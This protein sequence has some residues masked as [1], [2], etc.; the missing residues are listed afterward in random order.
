MKT[1]IVLLMMIV[2]LSCMAQTPNDVM[3]LK[4]P[5]NGKWGY[6]SK[7][8]NR[9]SP[10]RGLR[11]TAVNLLGK[12]QGIFA[13]GS[14]NLIDW[15]VPA[16][17]DAAATDF[18]EN[19]A[20]VE[21]GGKVGFI[22]VHNRF[23]IEPKFEPMKNLEGFS[24]G[25]AAVKIGDKY[26][27][28][29]KRGEVIIEPEFELAR[30]FRDNMLATVKKDGKYGAIDI[31]GNLV[32]E[33]KYVLEEA[34]IKVPIS[35][36]EYREAAKVAK[37]KKDADEY[38]PRID[39]LQVA[40]REA[41]KRINDSVWSQTLTYSTCVNG[42]YKGVS[43]NYGRV[44]IPPR[45]LDVHYDK[46]NHLYIVDDDYHNLKGVYS[47]KGDVIF[48]TLFDSIA[49]FKN[50]KANAIVEGVCGWIDKDGYI[51]PEFLDKLCDLGLQ[52]ES[53]GD[54]RAARETYRRIL[55]IDHNHVMTLNNMALLDI[56]AHNYND[57]I[58]RLKLANKL[59]P[60]NKLIAE[61]LEMAKHDRKERRWNRLTGALTTA[62]VVTGVT[63]STY[64]VTTGG[65]EGLKAANHIMSDLNTTLDNMENGTNKPLGQYDDSVFDVE[66]TETSQAIS[67]TE[68]KN[69]T[70]KKAKD[71]KETYLEE[72][73]AKAK[74]DA[75]RAPLWRNASKVYDSYVSQL[76][77]MNT[78]PEKYYNDNERKRIQSEMKRIRKDWEKKGFNITYSEWEDWIKE[79]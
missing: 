56:D 69:K 70:K 13:S 12:N 79:K 78:Y 47:D 37:Q 25:M 71:E 35:N 66:G 49:S 18:E 65:S 73:A 40:S 64:A 43:D 48:Y 20:A 62:M 53:S 22:D 46:D 19:L 24:Q 72:K 55:R 61:N 21:I 14:V 30:N 33:C 23:I 57:G 16:Q 38:A 2:V 67:P 28:I 29:D 34:M 39:A 31:M 3:L 6:A 44:I 50:G 42:E 15:V 9:K 51:E 27:Y 36:K 77:R 26:G 60:D 75:D 68:A 59:A 8:Q 41:N 1:S 52:Q 58:S 63:A 54:K 10:I 5:N 76:I 11:K 32:V 7:D 17:Y 4:N 45:Y 74:K